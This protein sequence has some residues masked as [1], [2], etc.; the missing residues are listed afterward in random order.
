MIHATVPA[1]IGGRFPHGSPVRLV[2]GVAHLETEL[3][4]ID[5][6][7]KRPSTARAATHHELGERAEVKTDGDLLAVIANEPR[8]VELKEGKI[9]NAKAE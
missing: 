3:A 4:A 5:G 2:D 7:T 1:V 9:T 6:F 8:W